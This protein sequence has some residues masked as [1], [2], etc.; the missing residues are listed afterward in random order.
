MATQSD[1]PAFQAALT[2]ADHESTSRQPASAPDRGRAAGACLNVILPDRAAFAARLRQAFERRGRGKRGGFAVLYVNINRFRLINAAYGHRFGDLLIEAI[3]Q[4][5]RGDLRPAD[6]VGCNGG[7]K[8]WILLNGIQSGDDAI[9]VADRVNRQ[10][11][12]PFDLADRTISVA[13]SIG[14]AMPD[15]ACTEPEE[16]MRDADIAMDAAKNGSQA[17]YAVFRPEMLVSFKSQFAL[18]SELR[19][20]LAQNQFELHYQPLV[21]LETRRAIGFEA[22]LR[23]RHPRRGLL[24]PP[25][26]LDNA[27][28]TGLIVPLGWWVLETACEQL[29]AWQQLSPACGDL[30]V[31]VNLSRRQFAQW[32]LPQRV[33]RLLEL[34]GIRGECLQFE[35]SGVDLAGEPEVAHEILAR[36]KE[37]GVKL[38]LDDFGVGQSTLAGLRSF[39][40]DSLK[41]D[42]AFVGGMDANSRDAAIVRHL[43]SLACTLGLE[44]V[45]E[46][47]ETEAQAT[48]L[49]QLGCTTAQG[50]LFAKP[51]LAGDVAAYLER[52]VSGKAAAAAARA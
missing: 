45:A 24:A 28:A 52:D 35:L 15:A 41:V 30:T 36:L 50:Y 12:E 6:Q 3:A 37:L 17:S 42:G 38:Q 19:E 10:L 32:V 33:A 34:G 39:P 7:D 11:R 4:R 26:F 29:H 43:S 21:D 49:R 48:H 5:L 44:L 9:N 46:G 1:H 8:F 22:L 47:V 23:W 27:I 51:M 31:S 20:A 40:L 14:I 2:D 18:E 25:A 16:L 13:A